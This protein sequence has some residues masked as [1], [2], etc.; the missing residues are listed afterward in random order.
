[1]VELLDLNESFLA[2]ED[3][4]CDSGRILTSSHGDWQFL[5]D[6]R[7]VAGSLAGRLVG[8]V[9]GGGRVTAAAT[10]SGREARLEA[11]LG[12]IRSLSRG[13]TCSIEKAA[14]VGRMVVVGL[15]DVKN[16]NGV[17]FFFFFL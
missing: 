12:S 3:L 1:M 6:L 11:K 13:L 10:V 4:L 7:G 16:F 15:V 17:I 5:P 2:A 14:T 9:V 8:Q